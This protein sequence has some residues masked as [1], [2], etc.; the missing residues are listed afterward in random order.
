MTIAAE[1]V[2]S[3]RR[4]PPACKTTP[5]RTGMV[6]LLGATLVGLTACAP[7]RPN[8]QLQGRDLNGRHVRVADL[9]GQPAVLL[10]WRSDCGP[11]LIELQ[12]WAGLERAARGRLV[13]VALEP[14]PPAAAASQRL[15]L[16]STMVWTASEPASEVLTRFG[17]APPR[18]PLAIA[19]DSAGRTCATHHGI[20]GTDR[21]KDWM[22]R[23]S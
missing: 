19:V 12:G 9:A 4:R 6:A 5:A 15:G 22:R 17:G 2:S 23:C 14:A 11:C 10:L 18:L 20:L 1:P 21:A 8:A 3:A 7:A 16:P 13:A